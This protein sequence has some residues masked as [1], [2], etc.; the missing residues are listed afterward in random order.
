VSLQIVV[1]EGL[2]AAQ[3]TADVSNVADRCA[4]GK[5][6]ESAADCAFVL[7]LRVSVLRVPRIDLRMVDSHGRLGNTMQVPL[8]VTWKS[9]D[10]GGSV[11]PKM[12]FFGGLEFG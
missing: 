12:I 9:E 7:D 3:C 11:A 4:H 2:F 6:R 5:R 1:Y 8:V 10:L